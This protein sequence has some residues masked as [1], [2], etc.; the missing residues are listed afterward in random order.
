VYEAYDERD[1]N[2]V[3]IKVIP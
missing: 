1:K 3:A 2:T